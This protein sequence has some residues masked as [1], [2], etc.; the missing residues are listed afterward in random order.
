MPLVFLFFTVFSSLVFLSSAD[1]EMKVSLGKNW[2]FAPSVETIS[3]DDIKLFNSSHIK[4]L[5]NF[6]AGSWISR[7]S[8]QE[9]LISLRFVKI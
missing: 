4:E 9:S 6:S 5:L 3:S 1:E 8:G 7:G 2:N